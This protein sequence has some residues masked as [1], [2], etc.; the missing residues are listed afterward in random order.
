MYLSKTQKAVLYVPAL[1]SRKEL[2]LLTEQIQNSLNVIEA[3]IVSDEADET[4]SEG[5][6]KQKRRD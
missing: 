4:Q 5:E 2:K 3:T 6:A 1:L